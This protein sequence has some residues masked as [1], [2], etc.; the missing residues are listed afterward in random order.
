MTHPSLQ[1]LTQAV[2]GLSSAPDHLDLCADCRETAERLRRER[3]LLRRADA[4]LEVPQPRRRFGSLLPLALAAAVLLAVTG[5]IVLPRPTMEPPAPAGTPQEPL[6]VDKLIP[7][8]LDGNEKDSS[9]ARDLLTA[10]GPSV[11]PALIYA[12]HTRSVSIR[13]DAHA[14]LLFELKKKQSGAEPVF[15]KLKAVRV[16]ADLTKAPIADVVAFL[17]DLSGVMF[18]VD[19]ALGD[20]VIDL[21]V[22]DV[23]LHQTLDLLALLFRLEYDVRYGMVFVSWP[24]R[25]YSLPKQVITGRWASYI[26]R[27]GHWRKQEATPEGA[28]VLRKLEGTKAQVSFQRTPLRDI[29]TFIRELTGANVLVE[30][31]IDP[32]PMTLKADP[33]NAASILELLSLVHGLDVRLEGSA[34][35]IYQAN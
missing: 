21:Q 25:L 11:L 26:P 28:A 6:D 32:D 22:K 12:R 31:G 19:P 13:P 8:F 16:T 17:A 33:L 7:Q 18:Y 10:A 5:L 27:E 3:D 29:V 35:L 15:Q 1:E 23:P 9:R 34:V 20:P 14:A 24:D 4:R 30:P 2:H